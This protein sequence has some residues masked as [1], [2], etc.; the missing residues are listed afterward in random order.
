MKPSTDCGKIVVVKKDAINEEKPPEVPL[1]GTKQGLGWR[2]VAPVALLAL[3]VRMGWAWWTAEVPTG[4][5]L[6]ADAA[7]YWAWAERIAGGA[8]GGDKAFYQ[9]PLYPYVLAVVMTLGAKSVAAVRGVQAVWGAV[10]VACLMCGT[11]RLFGRK[12]AVVAGIML[13]LYMP[14]VFFDG[15]VQKASLAGVLTA[16]VFALTATTGTR[17]RA[18]TTAALGIVAGALV[19]TRENALVWLPILGLWV[20][21]GKGKTGGTVGQR[22]GRLAMYAVGATVILA[23]VAVRNKLVGGEWAISTFQAGPNFYIG[24]HTG[25]DGRYQPLV[26]GHETPQFERA[27]ATRLAEAAVGTPLSSKQVSEYWMARAQED[28]RAHPAGWLRLL[29]RKMLMVWNRYEVGDAESLYVYANQSR[30]LSGLVSIWHFGG[31]VPLAAVGIVAT[32]S[33]RRR[34]WIYYA[35]IGSMACAVA[36]FYVMA[37]YRFPLVPLL[38]PFAAAGLVDVFRLIARRAWRP[39]AGRSLVL[40][41]TGVVVNLPVHPEARLNALAYM[42]AGVA[43]AQAG[44]LAAATPYFR[45]A[46][47][48]HPASAEARYNLAQVLALQGKYAEAIE[49]YLVALRAGPTLTGV[50]YNL[51]VA[52]EQVGRLDDALAQYRRAVANDPAD[53]DAQAALARLQNR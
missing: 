27:D 37:R 1:C 18:V 13:G 50:A 34:L 48:G 40:L 26:R 33:Q 28:I 38:V 12:A 11:W 8:W 29:G 51:G 23:P 39:I 4:R 7:G 6:V 10:A 20:G 47:A 36:L 53:R 43:E 25:A 15:I 41:L 2:S 14:A 52:Y 31:L 49:H 5:H 42:N 21:A 44:D 30:V 46:V 19:L 45:R 24:N 35:L 9:A 17:G 3:A 22:V 16:A 32:W